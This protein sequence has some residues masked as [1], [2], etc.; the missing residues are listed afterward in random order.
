MATVSIF[1][2]STEPARE[3]SISSRSRN[4]PKDALDAVPKLLAMPAHYRWI[5]FYSDSFG[6]DSSRRLMATDL[7]YP[8]KGMGR[9]GAIE[10]ARLSEGELYA[11]VKVAAERF[12]GSYYELADRF[13]ERQPADLEV[14]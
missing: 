5:A 12:K 7:L 13:T 9:I 6:E 11:H 10:L 3:M 2:S 4:E 8:S 14:R 1:F